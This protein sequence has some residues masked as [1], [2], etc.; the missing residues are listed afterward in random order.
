MNSIGAILVAI[1]RIQDYRHTAT[2]VT[3]GAII[4]ILGALFS[5]HQYYPVLT[6]RSSQ[7]PFPP[8][9]FSYLIQGR[10]LPSLSAGSSSG[11]ESGITDGV[12]TTGHEDDALLPVELG[13]GGRGGD[14]G[15]S[16]SDATATGQ[17]SQLEHAIGIRPSD[18][19]I[20]ESH[21]GFTGHTAAAAGQHPLS[22]QHYQHDSRTGNGGLGAQT[23]A[24]GETLASPVTQVVPPRHQGDNA[25]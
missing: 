17:M 4:G 8:R 7:V 23:A 13:R 14:V 3:W 2:Q 19:F 20:D 21:L 18:R 1:S 10:P 16:D 9:D 11:I 24:V 12:S 22:H 25:V 15:G 6:S 5:Y